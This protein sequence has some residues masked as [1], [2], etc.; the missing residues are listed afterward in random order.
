MGWYAF[1]TY[2]FTIF[3]YTKNFV[4]IY[5][6]SD[7]ENLYS[8]G[9]CAYAC[10]CSWRSVVQLT[11]V[12]SGDSQLKWV[13]GKHSWQICQVITFMIIY[14]ESWTLNLTWLILI[15]QSQF[16]VHRCIALLQKKAE[17]VFILFW[18]GKLVKWW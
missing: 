14:G 12:W 8:P 17:K 9:C 7:H 2:L 18:S 5:F 16:L 13:C 11:E 10:Q 4:F 6:Y 15:L 1:F 3:L